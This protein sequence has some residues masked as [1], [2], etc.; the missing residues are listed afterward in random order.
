[1]QWVGHVARMAG[2]SNGYRNIVL[3]GEGKKCLGGPRCVWENNIKM[4]LKEMRCEGAGCV[5]LAVN[6]D[7]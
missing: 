6:K 1:M 3:Q 2:I 5:H 7:Q 4:Y